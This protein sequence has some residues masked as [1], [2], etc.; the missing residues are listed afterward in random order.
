MVLFQALQKGCG[1]EGV[2]GNSLA[3]WKWGGGGG[4]TV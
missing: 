2:G 1:A 3:N 4:I